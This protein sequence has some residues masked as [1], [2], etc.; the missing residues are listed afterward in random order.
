M[1]DEQIY[2]RSASVNRLNGI[3]GLNFSCDGS[4]YIERDEFFRRLREFGVTEVPD[5]TGKIGPVQSVVDNGTRT[6][7]SPR[8]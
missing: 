7:V 1:S 4:L 8:L 5:A 3:I 2:L 6:P